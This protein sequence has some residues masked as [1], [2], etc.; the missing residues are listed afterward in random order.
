[1]ALDARV[2]EIFDTYKPVA[3]YF[4]PSHAKADDTD[5]GRPLLVA[6]GRRL[7]APL[8]AAAEALAHPIW[9]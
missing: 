9:R 2:T 6:A 7:V 1:M 5:R 3:F 8:R 4:D